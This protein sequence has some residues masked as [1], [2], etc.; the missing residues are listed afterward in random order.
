MF[1]PFEPVVLDRMDVDVR[2]EYR[3]DVAEIVGVSLPGQDVHAGDTVPLRVTLRPYAGHEYVETVPVIIPR[4]VG[5]E[6]IKLEVATGS[7]VRPDVPQAESLRGYID[8][9]RKSYSASSLVV[10]PA[11][12]RRRAPSLRGRLIQGLPASALDTLR[13]GNQ[14]RRADTLPDRRP[15]R[16][17]VPRARQRPAGAADSGQGRPARRAAERMP[18][19]SARGRSLGYNK[20]PLTATPSALSTAALLTPSVSLSASA[21]PSRTFRQTTAKDFEEGEATGSMILP[22]GEVVPGMKASPIALDAAFV[23]CAT[24]SPDGKT[25]YFGTGDEGRIYA[26]EVGGNE[27]RGKKLARRWTPPGSRR[28][29]PA[30][31]ARCSPGPTPGGRVFTVDPKTRQV[32]AVRHA[33]RRPRL[34]AG[35][36]PQERHALRRHRRAGEDLRDRRRRG[37]SRRALGLGRQ[38]RRVAAGRRAAATC[39]PGP[40]RRRSST[41]S[42]RREGRGAGRLRRRGGARASPSD[43][44]ALTSPSTTSIARRRRRDRRRPRPRPRG[45]RSPSPTSGSPSS[46]GALPRPGQRKAKAAALPHRRRRAHG[47]GV[48]RRRRLLHRA[49]VRR[50]GTRLRRH[51]QRGPGLARRPRSHGCAGHRRARAAGAGAAARGQRLPGRHRRRRRR[52]PRR[53]RGAKQ[54]TYLSRVLDGEFRPA[55]A[56]CAGT[57]RTALVDREP[58]GQHR[59]ARRDLVGLRGAGE[60][61]PDRRRRRGPG[62]QPARP[63][64]AVPGDVRR[65]RRPAGRGDARLPAAEPAR[66][67]HGARRGR[68]RRPTRARAGGLGGAATSARAAARAHAAVH[69][70]ALEGGEPRR[71]RADLPP[72]RSAR[73]TR[74]SGARWAGPT[75]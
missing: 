12:P 16:L 73:R 8:N 14:T 38:A 57:A 28:W 27:T 75:R 2:V 1:N 67:H 60:A 24:K 39:T 45:P 29:W 30:P 46:A 50:R 5:G 48:L 37:R 74:R 49:G 6:T 22:T 61:A 31:T 26:V 65:R 69:Q 62:R 19:A 53:A 54:A 51:R 58:L 17:P 64:R 63:L 66:A 70:A 15:H 72:R 21:A 35:A 33:A 18:R 55:G 32:E 56:C 68:Q 4:T 34:G 3:R 7:M 36:R 11:D 41:A 23:W 52:L 13:P 42:A 10:T 25:A 20:R 47:A 59:Q 44:G 9:M 40:P 71:R 43:G